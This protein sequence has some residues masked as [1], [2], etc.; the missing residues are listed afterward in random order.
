MTK[1]GLDLDWPFFDTRHRALARDLE[2]WAAAN[3]TP[4]HGDDVEAEVRALVAKLGAA[5]FL[6]LTIE[7]GRASCRERV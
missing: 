7:I 3:L 5:G 2:S 4:S 6:G 1:T